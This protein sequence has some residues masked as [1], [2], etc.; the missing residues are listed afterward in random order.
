VVS[1]ISSSSILFSQLLTNLYG[2]G[3]HNF[4][5]RE[6][7]N[8]CERARPSML[9]ILDIFQSITNK[10]KAPAG[11]SAPAPASAASAAAIAA[12]AVAAAVTALTA[13]S[14]PAVL[15][16]LPSPAVPPAPAAK[17]GSRRPR[18]PSR[19]RSRRCR[20]S[21]PFH[22]CRCSSSNGSYRPR[23]GHWPRCRLP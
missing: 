14:P 9:T 4:W 1:R 20:R 11:D 16:A 15:P 17:K 7:C 12:A 19:R 21:R 3:Y 10:I 18:S 8:R 6:F 23:N 2:K 13:S 22:L 5:F